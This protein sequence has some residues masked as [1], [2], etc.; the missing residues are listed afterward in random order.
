MHWAEGLLARPFSCRSRIVPDGKDWTAGSCQ[1]LIGKARVEMPTQIRFGVNS[2]DDH[3]GALRLSSLN[4]LVQFHAA[5]KLEGG[6]T[7]L[8]LRVSED[9][10][11]T[12]AVI[13]RE[14][15]L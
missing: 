9:G 2:Q 8:A 14:L 15:A 3:A 10:L 13:L 12:L 7:P 1:H 6:Q 11:Q 5:R 4:N